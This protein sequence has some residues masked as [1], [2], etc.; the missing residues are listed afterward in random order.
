MD[1]MKRIMFSLSL[2]LSFTLSLPLSLPPLLLSIDPR[3]DGAGAGGDGDRLA[4]Q[5]Q[6]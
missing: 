6:V 2:S 4:G 5:Y 1:W 3:E